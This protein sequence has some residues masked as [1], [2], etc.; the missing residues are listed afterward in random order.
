M[1]PRRTPGDMGVVEKVKEAVTSL[2]RNES[3]KYSTTANLATNT[4]ISADA[5]SVAKS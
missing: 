1:I 2:L 3:S 5:C 4:Q